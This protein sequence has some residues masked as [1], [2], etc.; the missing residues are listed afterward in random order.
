MTEYTEECNQYPFFLFIT[1]FD[2][3]NQYFY[4]KSSFYSNTYTFTKI[5]ALSYTVTCPSHNTP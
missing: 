1:T 3:F 4:N 5:K 2:I